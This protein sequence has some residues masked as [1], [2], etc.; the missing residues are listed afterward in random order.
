[1]NTREP[2]QI[3]RLIAC[4]RTGFPSED[5]ATI[6][7]KLGFHQFGGVRDDDIGEAWGWVLVPV[8]TD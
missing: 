5:L 1:M 2:P 3:F 8:R 6:L 7:G 4:D